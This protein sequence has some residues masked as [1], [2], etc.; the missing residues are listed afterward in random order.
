MGG[1]RL[2][3]ALGGVLCAAIPLWHPVF[4]GGVRQKEHLPVAAGRVRLL[5]R[6][7]PDPQTVRDRH[8]HHHQAGLERPEPAALRH[9]LLAWPGRHLGAD[10][11][12]QGGRRLQRRHRHTPADSFRVGELLQQGLEHLPSHLHGLRRRRRRPQPGY[13]GI[14]PP[15]GP[16]PRHAWGQGGPGGPVLPAAPQDGGGEPPGRLCPCV[17]RRALPGVPPGHLHLPGL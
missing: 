11:L 1:V 12:H 9:L 14:R 5:R 16:R 4:R 15:G 13:A 6:F 17:G 10:P 3:P 7:A 2:Q 8:L